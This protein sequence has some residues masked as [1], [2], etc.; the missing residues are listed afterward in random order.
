MSDGDISDGLRELYQQIEE[1]ELT[2]EYHYERFKRN[3]LLVPIFDPPRQLFEWEWLARVV[4][5]PAEHFDTNKPTIDQLL[6]WI[7]KSAIAF[8]EREIARAKIAALYAR[9]APPE[10]ATAR[11]EK[12]A[13]E[14][15]ALRAAIEMRI[16]GEP[17]SLK[18]VCYREHVDR[19]NLR[20]NHPE[21]VDIIKKMAAAD[22]KARPGFRDGRTGTA[23]G[24]VDDPESD[25]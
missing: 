7:Y 21:I 16:K 15:R 1:R 10:L 2:L 8:V 13:P 17:I 4:L 23:D 6:D 22:R 24:C 19:A 9:V 14:F 11:I 3:T 25:D 20:E 12:E 5:P 18:A